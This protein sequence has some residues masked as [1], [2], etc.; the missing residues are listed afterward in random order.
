VNDQHDAEVPEHDAGQ[1]SEGPSKL[2]DGPEQ[3]GGADAVPDTPDKNFPDDSDS[4]G[5]G[6]SVRDDGR[7]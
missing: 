7:A 6:S 1:L 3:L 2:A 4:P 5:R